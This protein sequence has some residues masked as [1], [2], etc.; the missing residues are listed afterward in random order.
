MVTG[1]V[2]CTMVDPRYW[3][4]GDLLSN[5]GFGSGWV[6]SYAAD[7]RML[8]NIGPFKLEQDKPIDIVVCYLIG[9]GTNEIN[10]ISVMKDITEEAI[11]I[12]N[13]N[14]TDIPTSIENQPIVISEFKLDQNY[15]NPF[16]PSTKISWQS[17]VSSHQSLKIYDVL[18][19]EVATLVNEYKSAGSYEVDFNASSLSSGIYF[20]RLTVGSFVQTKKMILIK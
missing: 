6:N 12:Y 8:L 2:N 10:S 11:Q 3:Y 5:G 1:G 17:P 14:F 18:G 16:N 4:S 20:Y 7:Q 15:P 9:R 19:N 13:S